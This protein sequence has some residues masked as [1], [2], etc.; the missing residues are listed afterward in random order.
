MEEEEKS[1]FNN[2]SVYMIVE[3]LFKIFYLFFG[4]II[5]FR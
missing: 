3:I 1:F 4:K 2:K 5:Y